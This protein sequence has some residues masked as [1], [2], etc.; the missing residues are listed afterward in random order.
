MPRGLLVFWLP[1]EEPEFKLAL[2]A[3][4]FLVNLCTIQRH[5]RDRLRA[6][7]D[8]APNSRAKKELEQVRDLIDHG[9]IGD[10]G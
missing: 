8:S 6:L 5:V 7:E 9:L 4:D 10:V 1:Q 3:G 2:K